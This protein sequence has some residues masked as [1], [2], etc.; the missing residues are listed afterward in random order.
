[1]VL[2]GGNL[3]FQREPHPIKGVSCFLFLP[4]FSSVL[5]L[6][7]FFPLTF[8]II[9]HSH[10]LSLS[11]SLFLRF[12]CSFPSFSLP[13]SF[14]SASLSI[15]PPM[16][17]AVCA[18]ELGQTGNR[19]IPFQERWYFWFP[20]INQSSCSWRGR[21]LT[22]PV[23][24]VCQ[25]QNEA[26]FVC[27]FLFS[28]SRPS[29]DPS[30]LHPAALSLYSRLSA[31]VLVI[32]EESLGRGWG[33]WGGGGFVSV[34]VRLMP[35]RRRWWK[36]RQVAAIYQH[37]SGAWRRSG[38]GRRGCVKRN[39]EGFSVWG[40]AWWNGWGFS[41]AASDRIDKESEGQKEGGG[42]GGG[43]VLP[44]S[45]HQ[46][47]TPSSSSSYCPRVQCSRVTVDL[48]HQ[49][50]SPSPLSFQCNLCLCWLQTDDRT[51]IETGNGQGERNSFTVQ[52][53]HVNSG[54]THKPSLD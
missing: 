24:A 37:L 16:A 44:S 30:H 4:L 25:R 8:L 21:N 10:F 11:V 49:H 19:F 5:S 38:W 28:S 45:H 34:R 15:S 46:L 40:R 53:C 33:G 54:S 18:V 6:S 12:L 32:A 47:N 13:F 52:W 14:T 23:S 3:I 22:Q 39:T 27:C 43:G 35:R 17:V 2:W 31:N 51:P 41:S 7:F 1:M 36:M 48:W 50:L 9:F 42:G 26:L 29:A 20:E